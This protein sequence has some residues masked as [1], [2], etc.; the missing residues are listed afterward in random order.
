[1]DIAKLNLLSTL[2]ASHKKCERLARSTGAAAVRGW[3]QRIGTLHQ[4]GSRAPFGAKYAIAFRNGARNGI[5]GLD[6]LS[7][8][9][10]LDRIVPLAVIL[11]STAGLTFLL[12]PLLL[13]R[14]ALL[15]LLTHDNP[16]RG[17]C[18]SSWSGELDLLS[19]N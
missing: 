13:G 5:L 9:G 16:C 6:A 8:R 10:A 18:G 1:M 12:A 15:L 19:S 11:A 17:N 4:A 14:P 2:F 3:T 7:T